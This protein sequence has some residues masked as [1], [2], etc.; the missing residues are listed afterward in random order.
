MSNYGL[1]VSIQTVSFIY[2]Q[3]CFVVIDHQQCEVTAVADT[4]IQVQSGT[5][6]AL[7]RDDDG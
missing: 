5:L 6:G 3:F 1:A 7:N 4:Y 2:F